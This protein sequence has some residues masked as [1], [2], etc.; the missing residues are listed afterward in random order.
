[1]RF[2]SDT[3]GHSKVKEGLR[4][5]NFRAACINVPRRHRLYQRTGVQIHIV[6]RDFLPC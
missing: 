1:M 2:S 6:K 5:D 3:G 4:G